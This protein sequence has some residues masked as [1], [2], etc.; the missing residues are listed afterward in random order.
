M[1]Q[2]V[3]E[4]IGSMERE[5]P[6]SSNNSACV[7]LHFLETTD[8]RRYNLPAV[9]ENAVVL[10]G[11]GE[12][13]DHQDIILQHKAGP[14][15]RIYETNPAYA[16]LHYVLLF[17]R[18]EL[19]WHCRIKYANNEGSRSD[20]EQDESETSKRKYISQMEYYAY[21]IHHRK[22][23]FESSHLFMAKNL[24]QQY[25]VDAFAQID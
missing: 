17:P 14:L 25:I 23:E 7:R 10:P 9:E 8:S 21:Q 22:S 5:N 24:F 16:P 1:Y 12:A 6:G 15:K 18:G 4:H 19:G 2:T 13:T 3:H 20:A 11:P